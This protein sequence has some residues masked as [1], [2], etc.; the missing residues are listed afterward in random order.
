[1]QICRQRRRVLPFTRS[2]KFPAFAI[3]EQAETAC[4]SLRRGGG[5]RSRLG[6]GEDSIS[7]LSSL[8]PCT[9]LTSSCICFI[10]QQKSSTKHTSPAG[11]DKTS[12]RPNLRKRHQA[13][14]SAPDLK[15]CTL[16]WELGLSRGLWCFGAVAQK[17]ALCQYART[18][19]WNLKPL[20][21][22]KSDWKHA[23]RASWNEKTNFGKHSFTHN[24]KELIFNSEWTNYCTEWRCIK[25]EVLPPFER[26]SYTL[27]A[28]RANKV[29]NG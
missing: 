12:P 16:P 27:T 2:H 21:G 19:C 8:M 14:P 11:E 5:T 6:R 18:A 3:T 1:M 25:N 17:R 22:R 7:F 4:P 9:L 26:M 10:W 23:T 15:S 13:L 28:S 29:L 24:Q 20:Y